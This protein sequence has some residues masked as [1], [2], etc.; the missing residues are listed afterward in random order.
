MM[1][2]VV[3]GTSIIHRYTVIAA[4]NCKNHEQARK[5]N[6]REMPAAEDCGSMTSPF[7]AGC[8]TKP[9]L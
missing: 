5:R 7:A 9:R 2:A 1:F 8:I 3:R 6:R 4:D